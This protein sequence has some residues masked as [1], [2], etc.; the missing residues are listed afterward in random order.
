MVGTNDRLSAEDAAYHEARI[1]C[2]Q[3]GEDFFL[4]KMKNKKLITLPDDTGEDCS[5]LPAKDDGIRCRAGKCSFWITW[6]G[7]MLPCGMFPGEDAENVFQSGF[8]TAWEKVKETAS[9]IRMPSKCNKCQMRDQCRACA[10]M[11]LTETGRFDKVPEYR[12]QM[13]HAFDEASRLLEC[14]ILQ[15]RSK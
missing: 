4:Q 11:A 3:N 2:L 1:I 10:A 9:T 5:E 12:C 7:R 6:D 8:T 15:N 13:T 14:Q